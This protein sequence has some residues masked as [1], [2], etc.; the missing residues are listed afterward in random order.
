MVECIDKIN[1][2]MTVN[3]NS[4]AIAPKKINPLDIKQETGKLEN[5]SFLSSVVSTETA[6]TDDRI[7]E[8]AP[9]ID[10]SLLEDIVPPKSMLL[11]FLKIL[12]G[13]LV[14][15][16]L[17]AVLFFTSQLTTNFDIITDRFSLPNISKTL[18]SNNA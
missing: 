8:E 6:N 7:L 14:V 17:S 4:A 1:I 3:T 18:V 15:V 5:S 12:F 10:S 9:E 2:K 11:L 13:L 16:S